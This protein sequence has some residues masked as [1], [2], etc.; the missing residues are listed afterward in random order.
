M[1][2]NSRGD[3]FLIIVENSDKVVQEMRG[4]TDCHNEIYGF[5]IDSAKQMAAFLQKYN[6]LSHFCLFFI[7]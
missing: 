3:H 5:I 4:M 2:F 6:I 1:S 7:N